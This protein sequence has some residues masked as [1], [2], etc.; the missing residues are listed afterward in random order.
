MLADVFNCQKNS[1]YDPS[2]NVRGYDFPIAYL[3]GHVS[4]TKIRVHSFIDAENLR[5]TTLHRTDIFRKQEDGLMRRSK[6]LS[7]SHDFLA[8]P[9][10]NGAGLFPK[11]WSQILES[12]C[13]IQQVAF[14]WPLHSTLHRPTM[15]NSTMMDDVATVWPDL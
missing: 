13:Y 9:K 1:K 3:L 10:T 14:V 12:K 5:R 4:V 15:L 6:D 7:V 11:V 2:E 8:K